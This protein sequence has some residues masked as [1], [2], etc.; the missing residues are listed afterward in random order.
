[1]EIATP[2][3]LLVFRLAFRKIESNINILEVFI[4]NIIS[5]RSVSANNRRV[6]R[7]IAEILF[8]LGPMTRNEL[9]S[10]LKSAWGGREVPSDTS[11]SS[12][13]AK[14]VQVI[15][16]GF[17]MVESIGG[18]KAKH[19]IF[20]INRQLIK[21]KEDIIYSRPVSCMT[22]S[23]KKLATRSACGRKRVFPPNAEVCIHCSSEIDR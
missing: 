22:P 1:M 13:L 7:K 10:H 21:T 15:S 23:E 8:E 9:S 18:A 6:R 14:N 17:E 3:W 2:I 4:W 20:D 5:V 12:L 16:T 19:M 11:L